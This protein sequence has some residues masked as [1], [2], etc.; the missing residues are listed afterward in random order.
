LTRWDDF[1]PS[2]FLGRDGYFVRFGDFMF[3]FGWEHY[4]FVVSYCLIAEGASKPFILYK[5]SHPLRFWHFD[6]SE[7]EDDGS[8]FELE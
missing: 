1:N 8:G 6:A 7:L 3:T 4:V 5:D 2:K